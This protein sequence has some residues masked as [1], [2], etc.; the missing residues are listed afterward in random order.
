[1]K[2]WGFGLVRARLLVTSRS[3]VDQRFWLWS[4]K[5]CY[6]GFW[7]RF[8]HELSSVR[9]LWIWGRKI[10]LKMVADVGWIQGLGLGDEPR[11]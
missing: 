10:D 11:L 2:R 6:L 3:G 1:M 4:A 5:V 7:F 9:G 8:E